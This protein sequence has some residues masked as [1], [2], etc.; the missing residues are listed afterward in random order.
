MFGEI[1]TSLTELYE[2]WGQQKDEWGQVQV[3]MK[4]WFGDVIVNMLLKIIIGKRCVGPNTEGGE[5][6]AKD[7][8]LAIRDSFHLMGQGLL[9]DYIPIIGRLGFNGQVK[10]MENIATRFDM[11]LSEWLE[12]HKRKRASSNGTK[13]G[14]FMDALLSLYDGKEIKGYYDGDTI[15][16]ATTLVGTLNSLLLITFISFYLEAKIN[17]YS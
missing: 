10:V 12:E 8:Q 5:N 4:R 3:E 14:D 6:Q 7:F 13:D 15:I 17:L 1:N 11:V 2:T 9:R 16:K